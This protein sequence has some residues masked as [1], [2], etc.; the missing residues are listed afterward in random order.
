MALRSELY[1][2]SR[3]MPAPLPAIGATEIEWRELA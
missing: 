3:C 2:A 1:Q